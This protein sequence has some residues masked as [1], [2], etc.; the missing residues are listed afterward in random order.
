MIETHDDVMRQKNL[1]RVGQTVRN[2]KFGTLWRVM[3]KREVW[4]HT[5]DDP[6][7]GKPR[8]LPAIYLSFW[9][10]TDNV[11]PGVGHMLGYVY[12]L[13]D[14]TFETNWEVVG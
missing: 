7:T 6:E 10:V 9:K 8:M 12:T 14:T 11:L 5:S 13:H 1:P 2:K 4:Q 3:E